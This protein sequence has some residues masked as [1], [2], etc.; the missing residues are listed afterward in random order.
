VS[1][2]FHGGLDGQGSGPD[3]EHGSYRFYA[4]LADPDG[5]GW[6]FQEITARLPGRVDPAAT[7]FSS[8]RDLTEAMRRASVAHG[9]HEKRIGEADP[10]WPDW[11]AVYMAAEQAGTELPK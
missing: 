6:L 4:T 11:Y 7:S 10:D 2:V 5:N 9:E 8:A 3:P 1:E